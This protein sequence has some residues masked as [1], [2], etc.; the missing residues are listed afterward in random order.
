MLAALKNI[1][2]Q[3]TYLKLTWRKNAQKEVCKVF[4]QRPK[5]HIFT[6]LEIILQL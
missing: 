6:K 2:F 3:E 4:S 5:L 1:S